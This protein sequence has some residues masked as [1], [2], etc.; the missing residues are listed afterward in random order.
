MKLSNC[1]LFFFREGVEGLAKKSVYS[2][3]SKHDWKLSYLEM[4]DRRPNSEDVAHFCAHLPNKLLAGSAFRELDNRGGA[5]EVEA[6]TSCELHLDTCSFS[7]T[8]TSP[9]TGCKH[10]I[11]LIGVFVSCWEHWM[12]SGVVASFWMP[13]SELRRLWVTNCVLGVLAVRFREYD[14][15]RCSAKGPLGIG[16]Q[17][18]PPASEEGWNLES[19]S[20]GRR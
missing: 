6:H 20:K 5:R 16:E 12:E 2:G 7:T 3:K 11:V 14:T 15:T 17:G 4:E 9:L 18:F 19:A 13:A 10:K 8:C 1:I